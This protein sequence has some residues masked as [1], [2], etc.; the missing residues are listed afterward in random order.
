MKLIAKRSC[1]NLGVGFNRVG[2]N[3][4]VRLL[5]LLNFLGFCFVH[6]AQALLE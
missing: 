3:Q 4:G 6:P 1:G 5:L 2:E